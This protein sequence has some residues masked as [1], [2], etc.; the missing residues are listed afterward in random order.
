MIETKNESTIICIKAKTLNR[1]IRGNR[2]LY[3][4]ENDKTAA[5]KI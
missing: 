4:R 3:K 2:M 1:P 5:T